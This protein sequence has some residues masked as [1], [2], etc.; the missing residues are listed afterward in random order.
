MERVNQI[1]EKL[2]QTVNFGRAN[3]LFIEFVFWIDRV[4]WRQLITKI[5]IERCMKLYEVVLIVNN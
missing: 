3:A 4:H 1:S 2:G 5:A